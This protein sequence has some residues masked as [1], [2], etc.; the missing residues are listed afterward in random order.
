MTMHLRPVPRWHELDAKLERYRH[1]SFYLGFLSGTISRAYG[2]RSGP[3]FGLWI[4][5]SK[6][7]IFSMK[8]GTVT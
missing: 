7:S 5:D 4:S 6:F 8:S 1:S 2:A 3:V